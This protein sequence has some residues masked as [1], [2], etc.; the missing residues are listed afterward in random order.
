M[1]QSLVLSIDILQGL[2]ISPLRTNIGL[3]FSQDDLG[4]RSDQKLF[5]FGFFEKFE[6]CFQKICVHIER[7]RNILAVVF[8]IQTFY[9]NIAFPLSP[10]SAKNRYIR[11]MH[12]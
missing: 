12:F 8:E 1:A 9:G 5:S 10:V 7:H 6:A 3:S 2:G 11:T 4:R